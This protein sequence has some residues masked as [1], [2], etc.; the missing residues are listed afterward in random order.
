[1]HFNTASPLISSPSQILPIELNAEIIF[2]NPN[3]DCH[4]H[5]ICLVCF[6]EHISIR[7]KCPNTK[8]RI[9]LNINEELCMLFPYA[10]LQPEYQAKYF[11]NNRFVITD[12]YTLPELL[13]NALGLEGRVVQAGEY[14]VRKMADGLLVNFGRL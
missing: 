13:A 3:Q 1:M 12:P 6:T 7:W 11:A 2:G 10:H 14:R 9:S 8:A 4:G 5:G